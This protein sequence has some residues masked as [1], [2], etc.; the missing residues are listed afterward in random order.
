MIVTYAV[1]FAL[2]SRLSFVEPKKWRR[3]GGSRE[4][5]MAFALKERASPNRDAGWLS[6]VGSVSSLM[7]NAA[8]RLRDADTFSN[9]PHCRRRTQPIPTA[10]PADDGAF[11]FDNRMAVYRC[12]ADVGTSERR[13]ARMTL[14]GRTLPDVPHA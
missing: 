13:Y 5:S 4:S 7:Q 10:A 11:I 14:H 3:D 1:R 9:L 2:G 6:W 12:G 8:V